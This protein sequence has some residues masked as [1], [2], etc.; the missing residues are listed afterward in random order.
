MLARGGLEDVS[1]DS[2]LLFFGFPQ[3][4]P[5]SWPVNLQLAD[6]VEESKAKGTL[7]QL[8]VSGTGRCRGVAGG[9]SNS[10]L[11][12]LTGD[13]MSHRAPS[14]RSLGLFTSSEIT[15]C[16]Y[17]SLLCGTICRLEVALLLLR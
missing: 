13:E 4:S 5:D 8:A 1:K 12:D 11:I 6:R 17:E 2:L 14:I 15:A 16:L 3:F 9:V 10:K 7:G